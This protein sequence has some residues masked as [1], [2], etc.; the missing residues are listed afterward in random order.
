MPPENGRQGKDKQYPDKLRPMID[1]GESAAMVAANDP[2]EA[3]P[4]KAREAGGTPATPQ[5]AAPAIK[6]ETKPKSP[7]ERELIDKS[8]YAEASLTKKITV[9]AVTTVLVLIAVGLI[10]AY[11]PLGIVK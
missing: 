2:T 8:Y 11:L 5:E 6:E 1:E 10:Y 4:E 9:F 7:K 3:T